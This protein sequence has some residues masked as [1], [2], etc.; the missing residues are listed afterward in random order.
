M[1]YWMPFF[2]LAFQDARKLEQLYC[3]P[4]Q[5]LVADCILMDVDTA[6]V[7][8]RKGSITVLSC[9]NLSEGIYFL[10]CTCFYICLLYVLEMSLVNTFICWLLPT[11]MTT[12]HHALI[13][14]NGISYL[15]SSSSSSLFMAVF[16][17]GHLSHVMPKS[18][19]C[20]T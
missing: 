18:F 5:R 11:R 13:P 4:V 19:W 6:V 8:D 10:S 14:L 9:S 20:R 2:F 15:D 7:S 17:E 16:S 12:I 1:N 3:D